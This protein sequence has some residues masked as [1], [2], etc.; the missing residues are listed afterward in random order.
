[1]NALILLGLPLYPMTGESHIENPYIKA[2]TF[3]TASIR[4]DWSNN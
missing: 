4:C 1:M 2:R 3:S